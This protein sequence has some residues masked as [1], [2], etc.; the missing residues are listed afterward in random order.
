MAPK[1]IR[2]S[3]SKKKING[4]VKLKIVAEKLIHKSLSL[5][6]N[7]W[8]SFR[9]SDNE[10]EHEHDSISCYD[11]VPEDVKEGHFAVVAEYGGEEPRTRRFVV[12]L[13]YLRHPRFVMLLEEAAEEYGFDREGALTIPCLPTE[14]ERIL[15][16][17]QYCQQSA[18]SSINNN[19]NVNW[20]TS[21]EATI[22]SY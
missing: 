5:G 14:I 1:F 16:D 6:R 10:H 3:S 15:A 11:D 13:N 12:P 17:D 8:N 20:G 22:P 7:K 2:G 18:D 19:A 4:I 21:C 9:D